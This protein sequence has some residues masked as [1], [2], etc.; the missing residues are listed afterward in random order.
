MNSLRPSDGG[1]HLDQ[2]RRLVDDFVIYFLCSKD[3]WFSLTRFDLLT[4][5]PR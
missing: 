1:G 4:A 5:V 2:V 3:G